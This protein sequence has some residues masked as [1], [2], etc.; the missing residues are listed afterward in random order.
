MKIFKFNP[1]TG[2]RGDFI[3]SKPRASWTSCRLSFAV[4]NG[5]LKPIEV[6]TPKGDINHN[7]MVHVDAGCEGKTLTDPVSYRTDQWVMFCLGEAILGQGAGV[8]EWV[9]LPPQNSIV[10]AQ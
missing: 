1:I 7:Y 9:I 6:V 2:Q 10:S 5:T 8:W 4:D 3:E